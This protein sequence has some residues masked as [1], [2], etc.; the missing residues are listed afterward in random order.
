MIAAIVIEGV[1]LVVC[2]VVLWK[3]I[4]L[5]VKSRHELEQKL[6]ALSNPWSVAAVDSAIKEPQQHEVTYVDERAMVALQGDDY[7][8]EA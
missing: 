5:S 2:L 4:E 8:E 6:I 7:D 3:V 1:A